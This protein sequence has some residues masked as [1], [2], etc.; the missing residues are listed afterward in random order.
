MDTLRAHY[1]GL[2]DQVQ[3]ELAY[4]KEQAAYYRGMVQDA[5]EALGCE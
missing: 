3:R 1:E 2:L 4:A 5:R